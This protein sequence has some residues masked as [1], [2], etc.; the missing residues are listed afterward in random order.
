MSAKIL[1]DELQLADV[2][3]N[4]QLGTNQVTFKASAAFIEVGEQAAREAVTTIKR[5]IAVSMG[6]L[7]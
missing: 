1:N 6:R 5:K 3:L 4:P 7:G 2:V